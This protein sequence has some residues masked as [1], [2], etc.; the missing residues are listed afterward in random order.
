MKDYIIQRKDES[1]GRS[2]MATPLAVV[3][4]NGLFPEATGG[5]TLRPVWAMFAGSDSNLRAFV[6]NL[7]IGRKAE[8]VNHGRKGDEE[9]FEFMKSVGYYVSWQKEIEGSIA[10]LYHPEIFRLDPGMVD[11]TGIQFVMLAPDSWAQAQ[12]IDTKAAVEHMKTFELKGPDEAWF[13][14]WAPIAYLFAAY[15]D[16]RTRCPL[17]T[18]G[19]FYLQLLSMALDQGLASFP[20]DRLRWEDNY[21]QRWGRHP[22]KGH[23]FRAEGLQQVGI[24]AAVSFRATHAQFET[25]LAEQ[26]S[27][28][29]ERTEVPELEAA[30]G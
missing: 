19:R 10:T 5:N 26:V 7:R 24:N 17:I 16:R 2:F 12:Q 25:F 29:F 13:A 30:N 23:G 20:G 21:S 27:L 4:A 28:F 15:V 22:A 9:R 11:P 3:L 1:K 6:A 18:D 14:A 8:P